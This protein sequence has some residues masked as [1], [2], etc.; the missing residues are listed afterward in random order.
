M[1][2]IGTMDSQTKIGINNTDKN[3][4]LVLVKSEA[5]S[6]KISFPAQVN[7]HKESVH[8]VNIP[9]ARHEEQ[10]WIAA[11]QKELKDYENLGVLDVM[12]NDDATDNI[13]DTER[14]LIKQEGTEQR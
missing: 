7:Y 4:Q 1:R 3:T 2:H 8:M 5:Y 11:K 12:D 9:M 14:V 13:I 6:K 10:A